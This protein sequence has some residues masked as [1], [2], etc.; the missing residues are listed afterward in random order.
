MSFISPIDQLQTNVEMILSGPSRLHIF[1]TDNLGRDMFLMTMHGGKNSLLIGFFAVIGTS[2]IGLIFGM[3]SGW[4]KGLI[5]RIFMRTT[6]IL[7]ALP[8]FLVTAITCLWLQL[9][10]PQIENRWLLVV[11]L[12]LTHWMHLFRVTRGLVLDVKTRDWILA[13]QALGASPAR[14][15]IVHVW[16]NIKSTFFTVAL[17]QLPGLI[18]YEA[19]M[20][21]V[22]LG[23]LSPET[24]WGLLIKEGWKTL[25][26]FPHL[27][28]FPS[29]VLFLTV[30]SSHILLDNSLD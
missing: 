19:Y 3:I 2:I 7:M 27:I 22:G 11:G 29:L 16:P 9:N 5:D 14:I 13:A 8:G 30:W 24:S 10:F 12:C 21:F 4:S 28:I 17:L 20:S 1:G 23:V 15:L 26:E 25:A 18:L 6:D